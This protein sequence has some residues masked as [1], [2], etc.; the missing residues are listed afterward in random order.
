MIIFAVD[1]D[2]TTEFQCRTLAVPKT[3]D[4]SVDMEFL[5]DYREKKNIPGLAAWRVVSKTDQTAYIDI[6]WYE[7]TVNDLE[8]VSWTS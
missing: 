7:T 4:G 1:R 3:E 8:V 2:T 5:T 6:T